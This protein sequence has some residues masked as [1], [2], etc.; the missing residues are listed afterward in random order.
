MNIALC[1]DEKYEN[2][3]LFA[4]ISDYAQMMNYDIKCTCFTSPQQLLSEEKY[5]LYFLDYLM[6]EMNGVELAKGLRKKF[7]NA[8]TVCYLT[9]FDAAAAE[10]INGQVYADGFL[11]KPVDRQLLCQKLDKFY[12]MSF[13][14]RLELKKDGTYH[15]VYAQDILYVEG[16]NKKTIVHFYDSEAVFPYLMNELKDSHLPPELFCRVHRCYIVNMLHVEGYDAQNIYLKNGEKIPLSKRSDFKNAYN[17]FN[18]SL[19]TK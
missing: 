6:D 18:F 17:A 8:V 2:D 9:S 11:K 12:K 1:D 7:N 4:L 3:N 10:I 16:F 15:T 5:D 13:F 14:K 19:M